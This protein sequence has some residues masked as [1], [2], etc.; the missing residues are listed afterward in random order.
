MA[1]HW[2]VALTAILILVVAGFVVGNYFLG[3][4]HPCVPGNGVLD[5]SL[6]IPECLKSK[7]TPSVVID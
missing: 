7:E 2:A 4:A 6:P 1:R 3:L 5:P